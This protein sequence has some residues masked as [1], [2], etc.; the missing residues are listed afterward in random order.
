V[1]EEAA[2]GDVGMA[3]LRLD[4]LAGIERLPITIRTMELASAFL[5][6]GA[7]P[8]M[9]EDDAVHL[10]V[11][12]EHGIEF[13]VSCDTRHV[14][15]PHILRRLQREAQANGWALPIVCTPEQLIGY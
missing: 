13:L 3:R 9:A 14:A 10:A 15:N 6:T 11:A 4:A 8:S 7:L 1:I 2:D 12:T 5:A